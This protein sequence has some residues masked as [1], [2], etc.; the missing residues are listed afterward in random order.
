MTRKRYRMT[1]R[2]RQKRWDDEEKMQD[3]LKRT[4]E[5]MG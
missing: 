3:D 2:E 1:L 4:T 5:E